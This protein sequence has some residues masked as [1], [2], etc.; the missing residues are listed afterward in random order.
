MFWSRGH[1][2][3]SRTRRAEQD[4]AFRLHH[5]P[6][7][8]IPPMAMSTPTHAAPSSSRTASVVGSRS[9]H[10]HQRLH[11]QPTHNE[12]GGMEPRGF[13]STAPE[14]HGGRRWSQ[15]KVVFGGHQSS[16]TPTSTRIELCA[17][18][19]PHREKKGRG[20]SSCQGGEPPTGISPDFPCP[21]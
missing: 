13:N 3:G 4:S 6:T 18:V 2:S 8:P 7:H 15:G 17:N 1:E 20:K 12:R 5:N 19:S 14:Q 11:P 9:C 10:K 16:P 21:A